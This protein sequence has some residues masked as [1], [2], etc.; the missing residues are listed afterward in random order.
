LLGAIDMIALGA[1]CEELWTAAVEEAQENAKRDFFGRELYESTEE[2][3]KIPQSERSAWL[4]TY[5]GEAHHDDIN[6]M[7]WEALGQTSGG[8]GDAPRL[9]QFFPPRPY[10]IKGKIIADVA[11]TYS[12][13]WGI[14]ITTR[15]VERCWKMVRRAARDAREES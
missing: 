6:G 12:E 7:I 10:G 1:A 2:A 15:R 5:E 3:H 14:P 4:T 13:R 11:A 8:D 9:F